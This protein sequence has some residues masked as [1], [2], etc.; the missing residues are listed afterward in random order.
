MNVAYYFVQN[1]ICLLKPVVFCFALVCSD[2][3][4]AECRQTCLENEYSSG[5][6]TMGGSVPIYG[7]NC[8]LCPDDFPNSVGGTAGID[9]CFRQ[10]TCTN[11]SWNCVL[12]HD[13][14]TWC[15]Y[16]GAP[17][18]YHIEKNGSG[19]ECVSNT[20]RSCAEFSVSGTYS[21]RFATGDFGSNDRLGNATWNSNNYTWDVSEC[22]LQRDN[23]SL[24]VPHEPTSM[25]CTGTVWTPGDAVVGNA[26]DGF[27]GIRYANQI[28]RYYCTSCGADKSPIILHYTDAFDLYSC[29]SNWLGGQYFACGCENVANGFLSEGCDINYPLNSLNIPYSC[30]H[31][32]TDMTFNDDGTACVPDGTEYCDGTG[33]FTLGPSQC[34]NG[35]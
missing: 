10:Q 26:A 29:Y 32:D 5:T 11:Q 30:K 2:S 17:V 16:Q 27:T 1:K 21:M 8:K 34:G 22:R 35:G 7:K 25:H 19:F 31:C 28:R 13:G 14:R 9:E 23:K 4:Y 20:S 33:C 18:P 24:N 12:Y 3:L 15:Q 6:C